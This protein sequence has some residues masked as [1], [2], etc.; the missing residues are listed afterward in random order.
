MN[1]RN[2]VLKVLKS[3]FGNFTLRILIYSWTKLD[4]LFRKFILNRMQVSGIVKIKIDDLVFKMYSNWDDQIVR[5]L[6]FEGLEYDELNEIR[7]F[8]EL[9]KNCNTIID[10]G[11]NTGLYSL[12]SKLSNPDSSVYSFEPYL[13][14]LERLKKNVALNKLTNQIKI[15]DKAIGDSNSEIEFAVPDTDQIC[16]TISAD[17]DWTNKFY[18]NFMNYKNIKIQQMTL[19]DFVSKEKII[20]VDLIKIDVENCELNVFKGALNLL[21]KHSPIIQVEMFVDPERIEFFETV[22][23]PLGYN[24]YLILKEGLFKT[25]SLVDNPDC[26]NFIFSKQKSNSEY[27]SFSNL[28]LLIDAIKASPDPIGNSSFPN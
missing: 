27:L 25:Q 14:N 23:K 26:H 1:L 7:L 16:D 17:I 10:I 19:D 5:L 18:R 3:D 2:L 4:N 9:S 12:T 8:K 21:S 13:I 6:H 28:P 22:L 11:A 15:I 24:C 20:S